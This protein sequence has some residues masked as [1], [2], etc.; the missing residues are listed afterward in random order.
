MSVN[1]IE[2]APQGWEV[3]RVGHTVSQKDMSGRYTVA[4]PDKALRK[5]CDHVRAWLFGGAK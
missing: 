1:E 4:I 2:G 5:V 3:V